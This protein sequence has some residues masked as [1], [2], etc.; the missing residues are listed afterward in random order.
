LIA[1]L[2]GAL[3]LVVRTLLLE[4]ALQLNLA[5]LRASSSAMMV[6]HFSPLGVALSLTP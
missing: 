5:F 6:I 4:V 2:A 3:V 1:A